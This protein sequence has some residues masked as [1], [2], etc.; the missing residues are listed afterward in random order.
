MAI[1][2]KFSIPTACLVF[3]LIALALGLSVARDGKFAGFVVG[4]GVIFG[5]YMMF[6]VRVRRQRTP[7]SGRDRA[8]DPERGAGTAGGARADPSGPQDG[9]GPASLPVVGCSPVVRGT[10]KAA[11]AQAMP[12]PAMPHPR[13]GS[14]QA[15]VVLVVRIP[16]LR[17]PGPLLIDRYISRIYLRVVGICRSSACSGLFYIS[18]FIDKSDKVFK[19]QTSVGTVMTLLVYMTPQFVYYIIPIAALLSVL[20]TFGLLV[21][22]QR[23]DGHEGLRRQPLSASPPARAPRRAVQRRPVRPGAANPR[24]GQPPG[25]DPRFAD[26]RPAA[27]HVQRAEPPMG[28]RPRWRHLSLRL[29]RSALPGELAG[30]CR[31]TKRR[32]TSGRWRRR[33]S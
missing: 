22:E 15:G 4:I 25:R 18:T 23:A 29:L 33:R 13:H 8:L 28:H 32:S 10:A 14:G 19:G 20:V 1:H 5:Y 26:S 9:F 2:A 7:D 21:A 17:V 12:G 30:L 11:E 27:A 31:S 16:R 3:A 24:G 6:P